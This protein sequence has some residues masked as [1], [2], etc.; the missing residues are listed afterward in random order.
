MPACLIIFLLLVSPTVLTH[1]GGDQ[2]EGIKPPQAKK[3]P[4]RG[5][6]KLFQKYNLSKIE[7]AILLV[8]FDPKAFERNNPGNLRKTKEYMRFGTLE[9]GIARFRKTLK[10]YKCPCDSNYIKC[11]SR[12]YSEQPEEWERRVKSRLR[13]N[14][15]TRKSAGDDGLERSPQRIQPAPVVPAPQT[16]EKDRDPWKP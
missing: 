5:T 7:T 13:L 12:R 6:A 1:K 15:P 10:S 9:E 2:V 8:E 11:V 3:T 14:D 4:I 16:G